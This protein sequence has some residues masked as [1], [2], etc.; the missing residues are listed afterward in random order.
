[1][2]VSGPRV[3]A[4]SWSTQV[5][6]HL[7]ARVMVPG[8]RAVRVGSRALG[9]AGGDQRCERGGDLRGFSLEDEAKQGQEQCRAHCLVPCCE[10]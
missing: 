8:H 2:P 10:G 9:E 6:R 5:L 7:I 4:F 1:M 3:W